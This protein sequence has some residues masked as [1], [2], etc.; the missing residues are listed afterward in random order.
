MH[1]EALVQGSFD[2]GQLICVIVVRERNVEV[3]RFEKCL[4][5]MRS[6]DLH[7]L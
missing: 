1:N 7:P 4:S 6:I 2:S 3:Q 5:A